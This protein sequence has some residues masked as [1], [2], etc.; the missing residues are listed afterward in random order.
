MS[1]EKQ[2]NGPKECET[3]S[4]TDILME[5]VYKYIDDSEAKQFVIKTFLT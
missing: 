4:K 3:E 5:K 2:V 1:L